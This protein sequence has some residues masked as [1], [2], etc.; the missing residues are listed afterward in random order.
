MA[1]FV[2]LHLHTLYSLLDGAIRI[3]DLLKTVQARGMKSVAVTDH[4][5]LFGAVD[6]YKKAKEAGVKP[7]LGLETYVA[8]EKGRTDRSERIGRH[9]ILLAKNEEGW[10]NLRTLWRARCRASSGRATWT[11]PAASPAS[12]AT[13]SSPAPSSSR[14]SPTG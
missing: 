11:A 6:F 5:N 1:D 7:I 14:S 8:G 13:S 2:H 10:A 4:G 9:L 12:T 3:K